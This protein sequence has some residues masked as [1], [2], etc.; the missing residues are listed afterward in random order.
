M[1]LAALVLVGVW[2]NDIRNDRSHSVTAKVT[3]PVFAGNGDEQGCQGVQFTTIQVGTTVRV[4]RIHGLKDCMAI[5]VVLPDGRNGYVILGK[6]DVS[7]N[8][9]L[10]TI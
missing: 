7:V 3:T 4:R 8:P 10:P 1:A 9:P 6:G 2:L 5:D